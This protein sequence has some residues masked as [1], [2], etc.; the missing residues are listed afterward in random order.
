VSNNLIYFTYQD[1]K[2]NFS[3]KGYICFQSIVEVFK[4]KAQL[5]FNKANKFEEKKIFW[6]DDLQQFKLFICI[7]KVKKTIE[8]R[9]QRKY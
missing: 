3:S 6:S 5:A 2:I 4:K 8:I 9:S 7:E 1:L